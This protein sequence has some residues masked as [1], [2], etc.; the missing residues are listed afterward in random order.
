MLRV[1]ADT[2]NFE[3]DPVVIQNGRKLHFSAVGSNKYIGRARPH[4]WV[5]SLSFWQ[6]LQHQCEK[7]WSSVGKKSYWRSIL[8]PRILSFLSSTINLQWE[9]I[10]NIP[11]ERDHIF[12]A[13]NHPLVVNMAILS[14]TFDK[15]LLFGMRY[16]ED[17]FCQ[18]RN[19]T[20]FHGYV[21]NSLV[22]VLIDLILPHNMICDIVFSF[23]MF[24][25]LFKIPKKCMMSSSMLVV[26]EKSIVQ[27]NFDRLCSKVVATRSAREQN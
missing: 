25:S 9:Q 12:W 26:S 19:E 18:P 11:P 7:M 6:K 8:P 24:H 17:V 22:L 27:R 16:Q 15:Y 1:L 10:P 3:I 13:L 2:F 21:K 14:N 23:K 20:F 5:I 4:L